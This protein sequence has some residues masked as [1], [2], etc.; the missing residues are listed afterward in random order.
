MSNR[1]PSQRIGPFVLIGML[2]GMV[3]ALWD[4]VPAIRQGLA[5]WGFAGALFGGGAVGAAFGVF[6][7]IYLPRFLRRLDRR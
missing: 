3:P 5:M 7:Y 4:G 2:A 6:V 1:Q